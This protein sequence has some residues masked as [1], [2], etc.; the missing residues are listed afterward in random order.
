MFY[1]PFPTSLIPCAIWVGSYPI[2][3]HII[4]NPIPLIPTPIS[5]LIHPLP[6]LLIPLI[7]PLIHTTIIEDYS[8]FPM[9]H[10]IFNISFV[11]IPRF[12]NNCPS[13]LPNIRARFPLPEVHFAVLVEWP[14]FTHTQSS[15]KLRPIEQ[16]TPA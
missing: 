6:L 11:N 7:L 2:A 4:I 14:V 5:P 3:R 12:S 10:S 8:P 16:E 1:V 15:F 13:A 9:F